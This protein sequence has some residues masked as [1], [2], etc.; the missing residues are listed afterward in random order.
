MNQKEMIRRINEQD[1]R[2]SSLE[3]LISRH[4]SERVD[5]DP[6]NKS[7]KLIVK[8]VEDRS[9]LLLDGVDLIYSCDLMQVMATLHPDEPMFQYSTDDF[10]N[11]SRRMGALLG[12]SKIF[13]KLLTRISI[14]ADKNFNIK[15]SNHNVNI[16]VMRNYELYNDIS[17]HVLH[18]EHAVRWKAAC[19]K[20]SQSLKNDTLEQ[21]PSFM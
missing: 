10:N 8:A 9:H 3:E 7:I 19:L 5:K 6:R 13:P 16:W 21:Q 1:K 17:P 20:Y 4:H 2:I 11:A 14:P 12:R 15:R 18:R